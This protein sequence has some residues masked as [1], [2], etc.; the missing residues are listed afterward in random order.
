ML[1]LTFVSVSI[2]CI[3]NSCIGLFYVYAFQCDE[4][5]PNILQVTPAPIYCSFEDVHRFVM[6]LGE[7]LDV[8][9][10]TRK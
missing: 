8:A 10:G 5:K 9:V 1:M 6:Y 7:A 2:F 4:R 3:P